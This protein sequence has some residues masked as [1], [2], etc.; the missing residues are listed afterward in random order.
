MIN[1][2]DDWNGFFT[3]KGEKLFTTGNRS[4]KYG[5]GI[6]ETVKIAN[7]TPLNWEYHAQR[8][9]LGMEHLQLDQSKIHPDFLATQLKRLI[10]KNY[11]THAKIRIFIHR[12]SP[13]LY[14]PMSNKSAYLLEGIRLDSAKYPAMEDNWTLADYTTMQK[15]PNPIANCKTNSA[16]LY[17]MAGLDKK[18]QGVHDVVIYNTIGNVCETISS[19]IFVATANTIKTPALSEAPVAGTMRLKIM[20]FIRSK[21]WELEEGVVTQEDLIQA[22]EIFTSNAIQGVQAISLYRNKSY[23]KNKAT[24]LQQSLNQSII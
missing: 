20:E 23:Q 11:Y 5:D 8:I 24:E 18:K 3:E 13:G 9:Q 15:A 4:F 6:F 17:V 10:D 12:D 16:L 2:F 1:E 14:T 19:N 21:K 22:D 7:F